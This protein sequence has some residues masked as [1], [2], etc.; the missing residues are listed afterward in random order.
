M[1]WTA[2]GAVAE[3]LGVIGVI[4]SLL[5]LARQMRSTAAQNRLAAVQAV[6]TRLSAFMGDFAQNAQL[7]SVWV[8]GLGGMARLRDQEEANQ[9]SSELLAEP[10]GKQIRTGSLHQ[11]PCP[12][13]NLQCTTTQRDPVLA[14]RL[15]PPGRYGPHAVLPIDLG[16]LGR[17]PVAGF[18]ARNRLSSTRTR[19]V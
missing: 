15:H 19:K 13:Q 9:F 4:A 2:V 8:R 10:I 17:V 11:R 6:L 5:Y 7:N 14:V 16:P 1:N 18:M 12:V 3:L